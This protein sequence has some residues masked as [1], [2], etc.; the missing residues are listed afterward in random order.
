M[1]WAH[2]S[3]NLPPNA[4]GV[5]IESTTR[6]PGLLFIL[7]DLFPLLGKTC[8]FFLVFHYNFHY[9]VNCMSVSVFRI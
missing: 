9:T 7:Y 8:H 6:Y 3:K 5:P 4:N 1:R 2:N